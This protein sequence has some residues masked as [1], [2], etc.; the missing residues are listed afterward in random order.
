MELIEQ[1]ALVN[2]P[3]F[4]KTVKMLLAVM[5]IIHLPYIGMLLGNTLFSLIFNAMD[6]QQPNGLHA[7]FSRRLI[8]SVAFRKS[9]SLV[10][11]V[12]PLMVITLIY[13]QILQSGGASTTLFLIYSLV[14]IVLG[15]IAVNV[16]RITFS[17]RSYLSIL[18]GAAGIGLLLVGYFV[19]IASVARFHEPDRW[20]FVT[21]LTS[22]L[23]SY[24]AIGNYLTFLMASLAISG[25]GIVFF[26]FKWQNDSENDTPEFQRY[27]RQF[28][29]IISLIFTLLIPIFLIF[30]FITLP[31]V[32]WSNSMM[33]SGIL[34]IIVLAIISLVLTAML[35][36]NDLKYG[37]SLF[38]LF[39]IAYSLLVITN[40]ITRENS[41]VE[42]SKT[43]NLKGEAMLAELIPERGEVGSGLTDY[44]RGEDIYK[45]ICSTCH[46]FDKQIVGPAYN[47][48]LGKYENDINKLVAFVSKPTKVNPDLPPMPNLGLKINDVEAAAGYLIKTYQEEYK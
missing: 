46:R 19:L 21:S 34:V 40:A 39:I 25:A 32:A 6:K 22:L 44:A 37:I 31:D 43:I 12:L 10:F 13:I 20:K 26:I 4:L 1:F 5:Y 2:T 36:R 11:G 33:F 24:N 48:V 27:A 29:V 45:R 9:I 8:D 18:I 38:V 7:T 41:L 15:L 14:P 16:Y 3:V 47:T 35:Q 23:V 17:Q 30:S 28:G 42:L